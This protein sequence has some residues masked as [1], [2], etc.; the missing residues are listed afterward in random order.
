MEKAGLSGIVIEFAGVGGESLLACLLRAFPSQ[1]SS[2]HEL[3]TKKAPARSIGESACGRPAAIYRNR[4]SRLSSPPILLSRPHN[5]PSPS[6]SRHVKGEYFAS[7][8]PT[9]QLQQQFARIRMEISATLH[10]R[11]HARTHATHL[12][13][14]HCPTDPLRYLHLQPSPRLPCNTPS[15]TQQRKQCPMRALWALTTPAT[16]PALHQP[17]KKKDDACAK[18]A[19]ACRARRRRSFPGLSCAGIVVPESSWPVVSCPV[20]SLPIPSRPVPSFSPLHST[21]AEASHG[22]EV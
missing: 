3:E 8:T 22:A 19:E 11:T 1:S 7:P 5:L 12:A 4:C 9:Q 15:C 20:P 17:T 18:D 21:T 6:Q 16:P 14:L 2:T 13:V 10:A